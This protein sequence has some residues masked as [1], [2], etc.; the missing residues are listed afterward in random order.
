M[1]KVYKSINFKNVQTLCIY[2]HVCTIKH[3][4]INECGALI[5]N[6]L[7]Q[8][9]INIFFQIIKNIIETKILTKKPVY[10]LKLN[11]F[12]KNRKHI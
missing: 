1:I 8:N 9:K 4:Q 10:N 3:E 2:E 7:H 12:M 6:W 11:I 5:M